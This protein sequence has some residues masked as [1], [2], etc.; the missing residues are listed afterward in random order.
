LAV[1]EDSGGDGDGPPR[2]RPGEPGR[3]NG[4]ARGT[5]PGARGTDPGSAGLDSVVLDPEFAAA[6]SALSWFRPG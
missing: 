3:G 4:V 2:G 1:R 5:A 6:L